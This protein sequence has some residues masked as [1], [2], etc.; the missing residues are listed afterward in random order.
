V[1]GFYLRWGGIALAGLVLAALA[2]ERY[3]SE[4]RPI[5]PEQLREGA[6]SDRT[7]VIGMVQP[8]SLV[9]APEASPEG[10]MEATFELAG[11]RE[12]LPVHYLGPADDN[13]RELKTLVV[14]GRLDQAGGRFEAD[15]LD[16]IPNFG[17]VAAAYLAAL[18]PLALFLFLM[19]RRVAV[20]YTVIKETTAYQPELHAEV[21]RSGQE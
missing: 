18:V 10:A 19:E 3:Q 6:G 7:R 5:T 11:P 8:G 17:F 14:V 9:V 12:H 1:R 15:R 13:L 16:L 21:T 2:A 20:L 4:V